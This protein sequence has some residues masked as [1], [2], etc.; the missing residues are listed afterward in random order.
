MVMKNNFCGIQL[1]TVMHGPLFLICNYCCPVKLNRMLHNVLSTLILL[2]EL[3][4]RYMRLQIQ[5]RVFK[6]L[7]DAGSRLWLENLFQTF[8]TTYV[9]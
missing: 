6:D 5:S 3:T 2:L 7:L 1:C 9:L 4:I 8:S